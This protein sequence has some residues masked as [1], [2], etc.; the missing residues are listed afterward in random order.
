MVAPDIFFIF[1]MSP[2]LTLSFY[3]K[4]L[5]M[6]LRNTKKMKD[7]RREIIRSLVVMG[8][9][10][11][12]EKKRPSTSSSLKAIKKHK[13]QIPEEIKHKNVNHLPVKYKRRRCAQ[14]S[15]KAKPHQTSTKAKPHK[16]STMCETCNVGLCLQTTKDISCFVKFHT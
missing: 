10:P 14:C 8:E 1:L 12:Q 7:F 5:T 13:P 4:W 9:K 15:T 11:S 2:L 3:T 16:T 6:E